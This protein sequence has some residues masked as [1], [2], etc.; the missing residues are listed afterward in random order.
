MQNA[1]KKKY[2][3]IVHDAGAAEIIAFHLVHEWDKLDIHAFV[4][5]PAVSIFRRE[6]IP[7]KKVPNGKVRV[8]ELLR[9]HTD[10]DLVL[11]GT[12]WMTSIESDAL[13][14]VKELGMKHAVY[15]ESWVN[16]RERFGYPESG[17]R[18]NLPDEVW[19][20]DREAFSLAQ[21]YFPKI[22]VQYKPN[23][24]FTKIIARYREEKAK[25]MSRPDAI[26]F[27]SDVTPESDDALQ[28]LLE[29][30]SISPK[31]KSLTIR[32]HPADPKDRYNELLATYKKKIRIKVSREKDIA[33][34]LIDARLVIGTET[35]ALVAA[36]LVGVKTVSLM[37]EGKRSQ[38]PFS[39]ITR[40]RCIERISD[41][42]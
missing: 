27:L 21:K 12:G 42:I 5:G 14:A 25:R 26:L 24:Y 33:R 20:G 36:L 7:Y 23:R 18:K 37:S 8:I 15:L 19:V 35:V 28:K 10:A 16:Y 34:N 41:L 29:L 9:K 11:L 17:W 40:V 32:L 6:G 30:L 38:L 31:P 39:E 2:V 22:R 4:A 13:K 1:R 3:V